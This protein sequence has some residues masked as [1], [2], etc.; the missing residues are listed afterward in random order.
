M[1]ALDRRLLSDNTEIGADGMLTVG[2]CSVAAVAEEY[3]TPV[4]IYD[5]AHLRARCR[6][7]VESFG[8]DRAIYATK[9]FLCRAMARLAYDEGMLLDVASGGEL[10]VAMAAGVPASAC[11]LHGNNKSVAELRLA[12]EA[13]VRHVI[14]DSFDEFDRIEALVAGGAGAVPDVVLRI[15][16]GVSAHTHEFISTGQND[17]KFGFNLEN[18]DAHRAVDRARRSDGV[19]LVGVHCHIGSN[20][21]EASSFAK[22]AEVMADF[23]I[24]LDLPELVLGGGL[25]VAYVEGE[26]APSIAQWASVLLDACESLG[27]RSRVS[28]EPGRSIAAAAA[29]TVYTVGTIKDIPG[30]RTYVS[31]DGGM[32]DN[33]RPVLYGSGYESFLPRAVDDPRDRTARLVG[34]HCE[35]GDVLAFNAQL[36]SDVEVGDLLAMPVTGAYGHSMGSNYNKITRPPVVFCADGDARLVVRRESFDDLLATDVFSGR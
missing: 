11:T 23:A 12:I 25:G 1:T 34:K 3:G 27:V 24:P 15:T 17:S 26:E 13:G 2:G 18:G 16:P 28:V 33:P 20:V 7:A 5:E 14:V 4:F 29:M 10:H 32:S 35:S 31:V 21:F 19:N 30:V 22:A 36:P 8:R 6:E 9:A